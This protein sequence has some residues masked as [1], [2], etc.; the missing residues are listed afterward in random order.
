MIATLR[1]HGGQAFPDVTD[2]ERIVRYKVPTVGDSRQRIPSLGKS[3]PAVGVR[4]LQTFWNLG[5]CF[6]TMGLIR[7]AMT[8]SH[9]S[10]RAE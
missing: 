4:G 8:S 9:A 1:A 3:S 7:F 5:K 2:I 10:D 6:V